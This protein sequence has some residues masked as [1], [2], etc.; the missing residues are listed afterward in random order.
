[1]IYGSAELVSSLTRLGGLIDEYQF[2]IQPV[3][4]GAGKPEFSDLG[5]RL[6]LQL[7]GIR[8][9]REGAVILFYQSLR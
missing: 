4:L 3:V 5:G 8:Q 9:L 2:I 7:T 1:V 6:K